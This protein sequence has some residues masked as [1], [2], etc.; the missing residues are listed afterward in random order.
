MTITMMTLLLV[1]PAAI[2]ASAAEPELYK[3]QGQRAHDFWY[4]KSASTYHAFYLQRPDG[5]DRR[6]PTSVGSATSRDLAH[7][8]EVG[9]ILHADPKA[10]WCN[11]RIATGSTWRGPQ[12]WQ[13]LFTAHGGSGGNVGLAESDDLKKW[14]I[15]GPARIEYHDHV[16]PADRAWQRSGL[17]PRETVAYRIAADPYVLPEPLDGWHYMVANCIVVG[18][19]PNRRGCIGLMRSREGRTWDDCGIIALMLD[20]D[21]PETPQLWRH[22]ER[23]YLY[24]GGAREGKE[25][26]RHNRLYTARSMQ[27]MFEPPPRSEIKLPDGRRFYIAKVLADPQGRDV[28]LGTVRGDSMSGPYPVT[29]AADGSLTLAM[30]DSP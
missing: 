19:P 27:G 18:R 14:A 8:T 4:A 23:W 3:P 17:M 9:E 24:F 21:R 15:V 5:A 13:M 30:P 22:G 12:R 25:L 1:M 20:Y 6:S 11:E 2:A 29:Y 26:C 7:W 10:G 28:L 16:V